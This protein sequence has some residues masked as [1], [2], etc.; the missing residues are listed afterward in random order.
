MKDLTKLSEQVN[1]LELLPINIANHIRVWNLQD[2]HSVVL[3]SI[4]DFIKAIEADGRTYESKGNTYYYP[5]VQI[6][7][8]GKKSHDVIMEYVR[9]FLEAKITRNQIS[10]SEEEVIVIL[11][12]FTKHVHKEI[13]RI[14]TEHWFKSF[15]KK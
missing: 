14:S 12:A 1:L 10:Y 7:G 15:K 9:P 6:R 8:I 3:V 4:S 13:T 2:W 11:K 5:I